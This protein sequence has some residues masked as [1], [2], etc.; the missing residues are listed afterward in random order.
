MSEYEIVREGMRVADPSVIQDLSSVLNYSAESIQ[1]E[2]EAVDHFIQG[3]LEEFNRHVAYI[4]RKFEEAQKEYESAQDDYGSCL[5]SQTYT[6]DGDVVPSCKSEERRVKM[7]KEKMDEWEKKLNKAES[8]RNECVSVTDEYYVPAE[9][10]F[11]HAGGDGMMTA[12]AGSHTTETLT[13]VKRVETFWEK[14][15]GHHIGTESTTSGGSHRDEGVSLSKEEK[16]IRFKEASDNI[17]NKMAAHGQLKATHVL[18]C[19]GCK[20]P[21][22]QCIC[23][24]IRE[25]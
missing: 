6:E 2:L 14:Y 22:N 5:A 13:F 16:K 17:R 3:A 20:R 25:R 8:I 12:L 4:K 7:A 9:G 10:I 1:K 23:A 19:P 11:S 18:F 15:L 24:H 21:M